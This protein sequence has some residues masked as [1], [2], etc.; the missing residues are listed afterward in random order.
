MNTS[1]LFQ[2][3]SSENRD[4]LISP[5]GDQVKI[6]ELEGK[7]VGLYFSA[8]W[9]SKCQKFTPLLADVYT[10][11]KDQGTQFEIVFIS[12]DEDQNSFHV[13]YGSMPWLAIP[14]T[15]LQC[16]KNLARIFDIEGIPS[17]IILNSSGKPI[18]TEGVE[19]IY[20]YGVQAFPFTSE[21]MQELEAEEQAKHA[22][23]T[24]GRLLSTNSRDY[25]IRQKEQVPISQL[26]GKTVGLY[27]SALRCPPCRK[28]TPRLVAVYE[29]LKER[30]P[31]FEIVFISIDKDQAGYMEC[32][33]SM[34]W[35]ALPHGDDTAKEL[36]R[37]FHVQG[38]PTLIIIGPDGKTVTREGR[39]LINLHLEMAYPFTEGQ[40]SWVQERLDEEAKNYPDSVHHF[41]H[42]HALN[43]VSASSG[44]G[45]FI[46]CECDEQGSGWAYQCI[47]CGYE[48]HLKCVQHT[49]KQ[50]LE[51]RHLQADTSYACSSGY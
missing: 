18:Q 7:T 49:E 22:S 35:L 44:G 17:L 38:I 8:N 5:S 37:Y 21:K 43:L 2:L 29:Q 51:K 36:L 3:L 39:N 19:L 31:D 48:I 24:I 41:R 33:E 25:L 46:C 13:F 10:Q 28:F 16:K 50:G 40:L 42:R 32:Y 27:F 9:Y 14:F 23:Q 20:R 11:L 15:D 1:A 12:S 30:T 45:P 4:F 26:V 47:E 34:P 6:N